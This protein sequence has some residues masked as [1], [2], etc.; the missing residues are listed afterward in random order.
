[1]GIG[2]SE[3][4]NPMDQDYEFSRNS[5]QSAKFSEFLSDSK[6][7]SLL[8]INSKKIVLVEDFPN[9]LIHNPSELGAILE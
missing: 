1:M 3:W 6:Y 8:D 7:P 9:S 2:I 4:V 5:G